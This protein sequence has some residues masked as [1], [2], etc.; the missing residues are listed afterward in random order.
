MTTTVTVAPAIGVSDVVEGSPRS[1]GPVPRRILTGAQKLAHLSAYE[2]AVTGRTGS[3][4]LREHGLYS[5]QISEWR[6]L[7]DAGVLTGTTTTRIPKPSGDQAV[8]ARLRGELE[9]T[10][11]RLKVSEAALEIMGKTRELLEHISNSSKTNTGYV[12]R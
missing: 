10:K 12:K 5:T 8:I 6:R 3:G 4:Y 11:S 1:G 7:R 9:V 2:Q